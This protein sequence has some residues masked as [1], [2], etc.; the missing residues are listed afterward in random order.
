MSFQP[1]SPAYKALMTHGAD[2]EESN[3]IREYIPSDYAW[4]PLTSSPLATKRL[5]SKEPTLTDTSLPDSLFHKLSEASEAE[6][7]RVT[8]NGH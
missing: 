6:S 4:S 5:P 7:H 8:S 1:W 2:N 3:I